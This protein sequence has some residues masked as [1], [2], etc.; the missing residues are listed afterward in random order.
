DRG[1]LRLVGDSDIC[2]N[3]Y[4]TGFGVDFCWLD[5]LWI[6]RR[7]HFSLAREDATNRIRTERASLSRAG[8]SVDAHRV[9]AGGCCGGGKC[10]LAGNQRSERVSACT[11]GAGSDGAGCAGVFLLAAPV[12]RWPSSFCV[13]IVAAYLQERSVPP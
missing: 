1:A 3:V 4:R 7:I 12:A 6:G 2:W 8:L 5:F 9:F 13:A 10:D 11:G